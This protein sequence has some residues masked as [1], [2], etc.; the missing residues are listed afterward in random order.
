MPII[1]ISEPLPCATQPTQIPF[2]CSS[3]GPVQF[4]VGY[5]KVHTI[6]VRLPQGPAGAEFTNCASMS[7]TD[8]T[9]R[10]RPSPEAPAAEVDP[11]ESSSCHTVRIAPTK[12]EPASQPSCQGGMAP[13]EAGR[14]ACPAGTTWS[15]RS[16]IPPPSTEVRAC[17]VGTIGVYPNCRIPASG[18]GGSDAIKQCPPETRLINGVCRRPEQKAGTRPECPLNRPVGTPPNCCPL[19]T[20]FDPRRGVCRREHVRDRCPP[21]MIGAPPNCRCPAGTVLFEG[22][23][24]QRPPPVQPPP[25][26]VKQQTCPAGMTGS[27]PNCQCP[28]GMRYVRGIG[29]SPPRCIPMQAPPPKRPPPP[30]KVDP[31]NDP[32]QILRRC[33]PYQ[34][35]TFPNCRCPPRTTGPRCDQPIVR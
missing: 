24:C 19:G 32:G 12:A 30:V 16:C 13:T 34:I 7:P 5:R 29:G 21:T 4:P 20:V 25:P 1:S 10:Q 31:K 22:R 3:A 35:G 9:R 27:P 6:T 11:R 26:P 23:G 14:C 8:L 2:T 17:P 18:V 28:A 15:G 33:A